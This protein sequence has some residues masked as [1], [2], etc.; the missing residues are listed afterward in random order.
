MALPQ[1]LLDRALDGPAGRL[2]DDDEDLIERPA[3]GLGVRPP[4]ER[5][6]DRGHEGDATGRVGE[7]R[8]GADAGHGHPPVFPLAEGLLFQ[9]L[10][11]GDVPREASSVDEL[12]VLPEDAGTH[13]DM[14]DGAVLAAEPGL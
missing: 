4:A 8:G 11:L 6:G 10:P 13:E 3:D 9:A 5:L 14:A 1:D 12:A 2:V 7:H